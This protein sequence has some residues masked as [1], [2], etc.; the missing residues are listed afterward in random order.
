M[1]K[2]LVALTAIGLMG[3]GCQIPN[4]SNDTSPKDYALTGTVTAGRFVGTEKACE[5]GE[6]SSIDRIKCNT[7]SVALSVVGDD[8]ISIWLD[9]YECDA[10]E[11]IVKI[12]GNYGVE[13]E[14]TNCTLGIVVGDQYTFT[15]ILQERKNQ[16]YAGKQ[17]DEVWLLDAVTTK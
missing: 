8:R 3:F 4:Q 11:Y 13:Y 17:Q 1:L 2:I 12:S 16:W 7:G 9:G 6:H 10:N 15:G 5:F 14:T